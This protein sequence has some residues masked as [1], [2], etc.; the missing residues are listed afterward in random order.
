MPWWPRRS[1][2][3]SSQACGDI[4][5]CRRG[6]FASPDCRSRSR[7]AAREPPHIFDFE[8]PLL[9]VIDEFRPPPILI[10]ALSVADSLPHWALA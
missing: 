4:W 2:F 3:H 8:Q 10:A 7:F 6:P 5:L 1:R 9:L